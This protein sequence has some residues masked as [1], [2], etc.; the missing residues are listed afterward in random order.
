MAGNDQG[1]DI[2]KEQGAG[3]ES[4]CNSSRI[5]AQYE[6]AV[7]ETLK[8]PKVNGEPLDLHQIF[9]KVTDIKDP[10]CV[11]LALTMGVVWNIIWN[12][13]GNKSERNVF[14]KGTP[15]L[16]LPKRNL[17]TSTYRNP[18]RYPQNFT[19]AG[20]RDNSDA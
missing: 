19:S 20:T 5:H 17:D 6:R 15:T 1:K 16:G 8:I 12:S 2:G 10:I 4:D 18:A 9:V 3:Y 13:K 14:Q 11:V 7:A